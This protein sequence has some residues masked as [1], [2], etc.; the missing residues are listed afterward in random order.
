MQGVIVQFQY[1][2][3]FDAGRVAAIAHEVRGTF[4]GMPGLR[5]KAFTIDGQGR[6]ADHR[7]R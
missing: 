1:G 6:R 2:E 7:R 4:E 3:D 5:Q